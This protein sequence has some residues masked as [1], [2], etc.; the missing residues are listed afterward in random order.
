MSDIIDFHKTYTRQSRSPWADLAR[1]VMLWNPE[2][3]GGIYLQLGDLGLNGFS[4]SKAYQE[5]LPEELQNKQY[6]DVKHIDI[7][8]YTF[9]EEIQQYCANNVK[10]EHFKEVFLISQSVFFS[11]VAKSYWLK[12]YNSFIEDN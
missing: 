5:R 7:V 4:L 12:A 8:M 9:A 11:E 10:D 1:V 6:I 3:K 2:S